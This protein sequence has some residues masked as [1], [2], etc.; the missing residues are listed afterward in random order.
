MSTGRL[1]VRL[2]EASSQP[3]FCRVRSCFSSMKS[4]S[5]ESTRLAITATVAVRPYRDRTGRAYWYTLDRP[6]SKTRVTMPARL[7]RTPT[8][9]DTRVARATTARNEA[10]FIGTTMHG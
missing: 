9:S 4:A 10:F 1:W 3:A 6:S 8:S 5:P 2:W 7:V